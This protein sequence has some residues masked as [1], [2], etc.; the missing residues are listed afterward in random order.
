MVVAAALIVSGVFAFRYPGYLYEIVDRRPVP[1]IETIEY[2]SESLDQTYLLYVQL[3]P[4]YGQSNKRYPV[5]YALD[6]WAATRMY[7][8]AVL[9]LIR[10]REIPEPIIV[11]IGYKN[12]GRVFAGAIFLDGRRAR[13]FTSTP[14]PAI[15]RS[16]QADTFLSFLDDKVVPFIDATYRTDT[17]DRA[18]G[19]YELGGLFSCYAALSRPELFQR[20]LAIDPRFAWQDEQIFEVEE[21]A[22]AAGIPLNARIYFASFGDRAFTNSAVAFMA[23]TLRRREYPDLVVE[24]AVVSGRRQTATVETAI[25]DGLRFVYDSPTR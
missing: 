1:E 10:R 8:R 18:I 17:D 20:C 25:S 2:S 13:D 16:G 12:S 6:G 14:D 7:S 21:K 15:P 11:G 23:D 5:L 19:G 3:P 22:A 24:D 9:P 4:G